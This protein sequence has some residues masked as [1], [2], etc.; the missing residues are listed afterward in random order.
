M[1]ALAKVTRKSFNGK[2][3]AK[4]DFSDGLFMLS[5]L[6]PW[7]LTSEVFKSRHTLF[8]T[9]LD[10]MLVEFELNRMARTTQNFQLFDKK[11]VV[12]HF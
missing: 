9:Y 11:K 10:Q 3:T 7:M 12:I 2:F 4:S 6:M 8:D 5:M 1:S